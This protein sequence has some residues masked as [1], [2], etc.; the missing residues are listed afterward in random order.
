MVIF[1]L[2]TSPKSNFFIH[3]CE[4]YEKQLAVKPAAQMYE[5][6]TSFA[7]KGDF[8]FLVHMSF[9][10]LCASHNTYLQE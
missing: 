8:I 3:I 9:L 2:W 6:E 10:K 4:A 1:G 7:A 5:S